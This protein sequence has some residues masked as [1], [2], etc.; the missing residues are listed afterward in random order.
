MAQA[1]ES[2]RAERKWFKGRAALA[3]DEWFGGS[4]P[5]Q[6]L[7]YARALLQQNLSF[8]AT[9]Q[10]LEDDGQTRPEFVHPA[11]NSVLRGERFEG[12]MR[13]G[14]LEAIGLALGHSP[15][16]P[17][18][19]FWMT[20]AGNDDFEMHIS[21][22]TEQVFVTLLVPEVEGGTEHGPETWVVNFDET[23][24]V[25]V[26]QTSGPSIGEQPSTRA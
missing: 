2:P 3:L 5:E 19:T 26:R 23:D 17:I 8:E 9:V 14:F 6:H 1:Q 24:Q 15:P 16:A 21:D 4:E 11:P 22:E 20:G 12:V 18:K 10:H 25:Q 13:Q 7:T